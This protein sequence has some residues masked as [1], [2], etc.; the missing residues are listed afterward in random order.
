T[1]IN[2]ICKFNL[3]L[4]TIFRH[5][6]IFMSYKNIENNQINTDSANPLVSVII[7]NYNYGRFISEA[8]DS[9]LN[10]TYR[11]FE[12]IVVDDGSTDNSREVIESYGD[13]LTAIYQQNGGQSAAFN[14]GFVVSKGEIICFLDSDDYYY[15]QKLAKVVEAF[16]K[17]PDWVQISHGRT[18]IEADGTIIGRDPNFFN[19]G[20]VTQLLFNYGRYAW[21]ITSA[22]SYRRWV[23]Q[24]VLPIPKI[25]RAGDTYLTATVPFYGN[26]GSIREPLMF[27]RLHGNNANAGNNNLYYLI[28]QRLETAE[29]INRTASK[30]R[31]Q[32][33]F[34]IKRD[35]DYRSLKVLEKGVMSPKEAIK[36][37]WMTWLESR[38]IG[39]SF[40][41]TME[42]FV[43]RGMCVLFP[44]E[45]P[46]YLRLKL[47]RYL[48][49]KLSRRQ[50]KP[51]I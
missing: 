2:Q 8:I 6:K 15:K 26:I 44:K 32:Q 42:R 31:L 50:F 48:R 24:K 40:K 37:F 30:L 1:I 49:L 36:I 18:S 17:N 29:C 33:R 10:Q 38:A 12:L 47:R 27:Y 7:G 51:L 19:Q 21:A 43:R 9:V 16:K 34:N 11:N 5:K 4:L 41:D 3:L 28:D 14:A 46:T 39:Y 35:I 20:D 45:A 22:L 25:F 13:K 23:L